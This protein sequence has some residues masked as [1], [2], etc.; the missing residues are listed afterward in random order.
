MVEPVLLTVHREG[1]PVS[2]PERS[3]ELGWRTALRRL[4]EA[5][6]TWDLGDE[7][8]FLAEELVAQAWMLGESERL[9][10]ALLVLSLAASERQ[11]STRLP[12]RGE[13]LTGRVVALIRAA[14]LPIDPSRVVKDIRALASD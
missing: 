2:E 5:A 8:I 4:S 14:Q 13:P 12:L 6:I 9:A 11:G 3:D 7:S 10:L 1:A